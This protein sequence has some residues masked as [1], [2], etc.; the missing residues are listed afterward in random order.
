[1]NCLSNAGGSGTSLSDCAAGLSC[2]VAVGTEIANEAEN[3]EQTA[4]IPANFLMVFW[5]SIQSS[6][7]PKAIEADGENSYDWLTS[8][9][10][11]NY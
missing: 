11:N 1:M 5:A 4:M 10:S 8:W 6:L 3:S 2:A 9:V 7:R